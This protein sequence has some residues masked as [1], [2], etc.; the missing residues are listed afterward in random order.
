MPELI[1]AGE[2]DRYQSS[3]L[4]RA[5][6]LLCWRVTSVA[7]AAKTACVKMCVHPEL[8]SLATT[9]CAMSNR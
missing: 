8:A 4:V 9:T 1:P 5:L 3:G 2:Q 6:I 7:L